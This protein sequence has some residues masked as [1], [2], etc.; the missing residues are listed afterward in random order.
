MCFTG[1]LG[2][3]RKIKWGKARKKPVVV[4]F[5]EV[6]PKQSFSG[7]TEILNPKKGETIETREGKLIAIAGEDYIIRGVEGE[8]YPI[9]KEI[10]FKTY[11]ILEDLK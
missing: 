8:I 5:R 11:E 7:S 10:F 1:C 4:E 6:Q 2:R 9:N 3:D